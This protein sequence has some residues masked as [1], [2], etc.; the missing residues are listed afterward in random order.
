MNDRRQAQ[1]PLPIALALGAVVFAGG[2]VLARQGLGEWQ[3]RIAGASSIRRSFD[4]LARRAGVELLAGE[5]LP[6]LETSSSE[7]RFAGQAKSRGDL[8]PRQAAAAVSGIVVTRR[9]SLPGDAAPRDFTIRFAWDGTPR[10]ISWEGNPWVGFGAVAARQTASPEDMD[11]LARVLLRP[12]ESFGSRQQTTISGYPVTAYAIAGG[13]NSRSSGPGGSREHVSVLCPPGGAIA[14][15]RRGGGPEWAVANARRFTIP[16]FVWPAVQMLVYFLIVLAL[17]VTLLVRRRLAMTNAALLA[18]AAFIVS[19]PSFLG[20]DPTLQGAAWALFGAFTQ[21]V[22]ILLLWSAGESFL[23]STEPDFTTSLD[24]LRTGRLGPRG[25]RSLLLG[26]AAG[27]ALAGLALAALAAAAPTLRVWPE[28]AG[29]PLPIF[30]S[31]SSPLGAGIRLAAGIVLL[32]SLARHLVAKRWV[33]PLAALAGAVL[34]APLSLHPYALELAANLV[35]VGILVGLARWAGLTALLTAAVAYFLVPAA[36]VAAFHASWLPASLAV[37]GGGVAALLA[38]GI[39]AVRRPPEVE[40]E[41]LAPPAFMRRLEDER[42]IKYEMDLLSRMQLGLLPQVPAISGWQI[43]AS[44]LLATEASGD[45]YDFLTDEAGMLWVAAGDVA[46]HGYSCSIMQAMTTAALTSL[47]SPERTPSQ[48]LREVDR[49]LRRGGAQRHFASLALLRLDPA[50][51][52]AL[53]ANAG[54]PFP[55]FLRITGGE[56]AEVNL[57]GLPLGQGPAR[58]YQDEP[59]RLTPGSLL[60]F[61]S[62]GLFEAVDWKQEPY[63]YDRPREVL[64]AARDLPAAGIVE[65]LLADWRRHLR[66]EAPQDDTTIVVIKRLVA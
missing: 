11:R 6:H 32:L 61:C 2:V 63:G 23:R 16:G 4:D 45:L 21:A 3:S 34:L 54:H 25:G 38:F 5:S 66:S 27:T 58:Q 19:A 48:V 28:N 60:V 7:A 50:T 40:L 15:A 31:F 26:L 53:L 13:R 62:D 18:A 17:F 39:I 56:F 29:V 57:P 52:V 22:W 65:A 59:L 64:Q 37:S 12:G 41:R 55:F 30:T 10:S 43:A 9:G 8:S 33:G 46:G 44:S 49:V 24:A 35:L 14:A 36:T 1:L 47:V 42:R 51:G 20:S